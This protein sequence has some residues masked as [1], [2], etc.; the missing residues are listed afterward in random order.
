MTTA[1]VAAPSSFFR[2]YRF[3]EERNRETDACLQKWTRLLD[4]SLSHK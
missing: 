4:L 2:E 3:L 1:F